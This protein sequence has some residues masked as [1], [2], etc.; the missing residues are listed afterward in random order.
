M[1]RLG[2]LCGAAFAALVL[3]AAVREYVRRIEAQ[4]AQVPA[5]GALG[6]Q[7]RG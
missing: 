5:D 6:F 1:V 7:R 2:Q 3:T 4:W